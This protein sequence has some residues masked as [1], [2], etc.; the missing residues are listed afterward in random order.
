MFT[1][2]TKIINIIAMLS[3]ISHLFKIHFLMSVARYIKINLIKESY[4]QV[5][6]YYINNTKLYSVICIIVKITITP[7][8]YNLYTFRIY[9]FVTHN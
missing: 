3:W 6:S 1:Q 9:L 5:S 2:F 8:L 4:Y 7:Y